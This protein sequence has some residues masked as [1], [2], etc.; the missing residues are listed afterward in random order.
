MVVIDGKKIAAE[1]LQQ[2]SNQVTALPFVPV[3]CDIL[4]GK[5]PASVQYVKMKAEAA[6]KIGMKFLNA[7]FLADI[8]TEQLVQEIKVI[9]LTKNLCGLIIQLPLPGHINKT[10]VLNAID[11]EIDVDCTGEINSQLFYSGKAYLQFPT[12]KAI[13]KILDLSGVNLTTKNTLIMGFG[14]LVGRPVSFLFQQRNWPH[15]VARSKTENVDRLLSEADVIVSAVGKPKLITGEKTKPG[16]IVVDA[17]TS[18][19]N[20]GGLVGDVDFA[21]VKDRASLVSPV[22]GGVGPITVACLL[23]NV[24]SVAKMKN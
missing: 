21:S 23:E 4:V 18:E 2:L 8:T 17:G 11:P 24:Y 6:E 9:N 15:T 7:N 12:A 13:M 16:C 10:M 22:P 14:Q 1:I 19:S 3:F 5:D 20:S